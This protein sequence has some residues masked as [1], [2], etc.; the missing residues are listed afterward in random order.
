[1]K[2]FADATFTSNP[3]LLAHAN[4]DGYNVFHFASTSGSLPV[5]KYLVNLINL[6]SGIGINVK[7]LLQSKTK[8]GY[9]P[10]HLSC[11]NGHIEVVK[12][13]ATL[14][15]STISMV[16]NNGRGLMH[17]AA[18]STNVKLIEYLAD[19]HNFE[20]DTSNSTGVTPLHIA[21]EI[22]NF[23]AFKAL[24]NYTG[25]NGNYNPV[26]HDGRTPFSLACKNGHYLIS[27]YLIE[28]LSVSVDVSFTTSTTYTPL[29]LAASNN[30]VALK[31]YFT[32]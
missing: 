32:Q 8:E 25:K 24:I 4:D 13:L 27:S 18:H 3:L 12:S 16:D 29:H 26:S 11:V 14:C 17:A 6:L 19:E 20:S 7:D 31:L 28:D 30:K 5:V 10:L 21:A 15:P 9:T 1:M 23:I 22:G 2:S